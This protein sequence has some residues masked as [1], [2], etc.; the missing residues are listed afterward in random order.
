MIKFQEIITLSPT[1]LT[2]TTR[3][4]AFL[5][6]SN[7]KNAN[8]YSCYRNY[9]GF[10]CKESKNINSLLSFFKHVQCLPDC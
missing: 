3:K 8:A 1:Y 4:V 2:D 5:S 9:S 7:Y 10:F 6:R